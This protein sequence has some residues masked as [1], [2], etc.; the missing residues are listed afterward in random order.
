MS[1]PTDSVPKGSEPQRDNVETAVKGNDAAVAEKPEYRSLGHRSFGRYELLIEMGSGGMATLYLAR[2]SGPQNFEKLL[3]I[4]KIHDHLARETDFVNMFLDEARISALIHHPNV[5][6]IFDLGEFDQAYFIAMEY[7]HGQNLIDVIKAALR[8]PGAFGWEHACRL[9]ADTA[10]GLHAAH[11]LR[12]KDGSSLEVVH[13]DVSPQNILVAY[14]GHVK[15]VDFGIAFAAER[16]SET[17]AGTLKGKLGYMS[18][19]QTNDTPVDRR[20]DIFSLG[21]VLYELC[22]LKRLFRGSTEAETIMLVREVNIP[23]PR[24]V[25]PELP[26]ELERIILKALQKEPD[27]RYATA[28]QLAEDLDAFLVSQKKVVNRASLAG[29]MKQLFYDR[30]RLKD[31]QIQR[32]MDEP[33]TDPLR[34][35]GM[36]ATTDH[37]LVSPE[38]VQKGSSKLVFGLVG[39]AV[40]ALA[41]AAVIFFTFGGKTPDKESTNTTDN[42]PPMSRP[43]TPAPLPNTVTIRIDVKPPVPNAIVIFRGKTHEGPTFKV[44]VPRTDRAERLRVRAPGYGED[45]LVVVPVA[46]S[47]VT[48]ELVK[49]PAAKPTVRVRPRAR[50]RPRWRP[51]PRRPMSGLRDFPD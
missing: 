39:G 43:T 10:A 16:V 40:V 31:E 25:N 13:R 42:S 14:D 33:D 21:I 11:E 49:K 12:R 1:A 20:A 3:A 34:G 23:R 29:L 37:S 36:G 6:S 51:R 17:K 48:V 46:D 50:P 28:E 45:S 9:A 5:A 8:Q 35:V 32:A 7:V 30:R 38:V 27:Q 18:P 47:R 41:V 4:K 15:V 44:V 22:T 2:L 19:E 24:E 26:V